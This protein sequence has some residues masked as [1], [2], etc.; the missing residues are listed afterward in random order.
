MIDY[1]IEES[2]LSEYIRDLYRIRDEEMI[3]DVWLYKVQDKGYEEFKSQIMSA[4]NATDA[5]DTDLE[6]IAKFS[7][8]IFEDMNNSQS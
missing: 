8:Q 1:L 3:W 4:V 7:Q 5:K 6:S 2:R